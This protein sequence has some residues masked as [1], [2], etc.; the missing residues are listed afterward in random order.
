[1]FSSNR[2]VALWETVLCLLIVLAALVVAVRTKEPGSEPRHGLLRDFATLDAGAACLREGCSPYDVPALDRMMVERG[3][4]PLTNW[5]LELPIYPPTTI[6]LF[7]PFTWLSEAHAS[8]GLWL[9]ILVVDL[10]AGWACF[11]RGSL[12]ADIP[13][14]VRAILFALLL[15]AGEARFGLLLGNPVTIAVP[16]VLFCCLDSAPSRR[17]LRIVLLSIACLLKPTVGLPFLLPL[18]VKPSDGWRTVLRAMA[19][20]AVFAVAVLAWC[21]VHPSLAGWMTDL[22]RELALGAS[23]GNSMNPSAR[24]SVLDTLL[25]LEY[26]VGYWVGAPHTRAILAV[27]GWVVLGAGLLFGAWR[28]AK[29]PSRLRVLLVVAA[30]A[31][32]T[33]LPVYHRFYDNIL[34]LLTL[35]FAVVAI[36]SRI[37]TLPAIASLLAYTEGVLQ[38]FHHSPRLTALEGVERPRSIGDFLLHRLDALCALILCAVLVAALLAFRVPRDADFEDMSL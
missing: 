19:C 20:M 4:A 34:L 25:N 23:S 26:L 36:H 15:A 14:V 3:H 30:T 29:N 28:T 8:A 5:A 16:L 6:A 17:N 7:V 2:P 33:L 21:A 35:P 38:W 12:L 32:W 11:V 22:H 24:T 9:L 31:A 10:I 37:Q 13:P 27:A 1:L 18:L